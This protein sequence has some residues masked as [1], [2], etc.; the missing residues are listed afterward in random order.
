[1]SKVYNYLILA[2]VLTLLLQLAGLPT[3][4][5]ILV[6]LGLSDYNVAGLSLGNFYVGITAL[7]IAGAAIGIAGTVTAGLLGSKTSETYLMSALVSGIFVVLFSTYVAILNFTKD[8]GYVFYIVLL[9]FLPLIAG[10]GIAMIQ[11]WRGADV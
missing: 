7:F 8:Y 10:L 6:W 1:M 3:G 4:A 5:T 2:V 9:L 11:F